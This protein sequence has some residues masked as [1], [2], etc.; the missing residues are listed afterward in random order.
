MLSSQPL[1][2]EANL[3]KGVSGL[4]TREVGLIKGVSSNNSIEMFITFSPQTYHHGES[5]R[6]NVAIS[7]RSNK[8][9]KRIKL[10]GVYSRIGVVCPEF[11]IRSEG[12]YVLILDGGSPARGGDKVGIT[13][14]FRIGAVLK[15]RG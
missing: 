13:G 15:F 10:Q 7:N 1:V 5:I 11:G 8:T 4:V 3:D 2:V 9:V 14:E 12:V 6:I